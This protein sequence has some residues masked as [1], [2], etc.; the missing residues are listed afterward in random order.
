M[1]FLALFRCESPISPLFANSLFLLV[2][3]TPLIFMLYPVRHGKWYIHPW[4][5][6]AINL[7]HNDKPFDT[8]IYGVP[9]HMR[10]S[11][12]L[13]NPTSR[14][15]RY[16]ARRPIPTEV[17]RLIYGM[18]MWLVINHH[19]AEEMIYTFIYHHSSW[20][21]YYFVEHLNGRQEKLQV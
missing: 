12:L 13:V 5:R 14:I 21:W 3:Q 4:L 11:P 9:H 20:K 7:L 15:D 2:H 10:D 18:G 19:H 8:H 16:F 6:A 17:K 1:S